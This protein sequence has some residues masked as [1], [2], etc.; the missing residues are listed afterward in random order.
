MLG[1]RLSEERLEILGAR[2]GQPRRLGG[3]AVDADGAVLGLHEL[4]VRVRAEGED[5]DD[6]EDEEQDAAGRDS[7]CASALRSVSAG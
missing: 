1:G 7:S 5:G 6:D 2:L 3:V 4:Q